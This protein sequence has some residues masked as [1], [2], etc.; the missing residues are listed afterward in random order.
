M[1]FSRF[2]CR[3][4]AFVILN[5]ILLRVKILQVLSSGVKPSFVTCGVLRF[6]SALDQVKCLLET[7]LASSFTLSYNFK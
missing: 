7:K 2:Y 5:E 3:P 1:H 6:S 4:I